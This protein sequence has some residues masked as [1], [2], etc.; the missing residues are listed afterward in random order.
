MSTTATAKRPSTLTAV[1][2]IATAGLGTALK[3]VPV[4]STV[5]QAR[6]I[7]GADETDVAYVEGQPADEHLVLEADAHVEFRPEATPEKG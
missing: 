4:G 5:G 3:Q 2:P 1:E 6:A 7:I